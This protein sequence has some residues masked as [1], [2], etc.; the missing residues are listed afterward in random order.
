MVMFLST[1]TNVIFIAGQTASG[2]SLFALN[3][4]RK[5]NGAII[6]ADSMQV[7]DTLHILTSRPS[8]QEMKSIPHYLY[9]HVPAQEVYSTG[10][11]LSSAIKTIEEVKK[12]GFL[13]IIIG[14]TGLYFRALMGQIS[15]IPDI[16]TKIRENI[17][18]KLK[19]HGSHVLY[20]ELRDLDSIAA[21]QI[22]PSDA[23]RIARALEVKVSSGRS[24]TEFWKKHSN[25]VINLEKAQ[26]IIIMPEINELKNR[27][28]L[29]FKKML[30]SGAIDEVRNLLKMNLSFDLPIMKAIGVRDI[31]ALLN[32][33]INY[34]RTLQNGVIATNQYAKRQRTWL[35]NQFKDDWIRITS[36]DDLL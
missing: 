17:R 26:K 33:E 19:K 4:A 34:D 22:H 6:N 5:L 29:R 8:D 13:P 20:N 32:G 12:N 36:V 35:S 10:K 18:E 30:D 31:I 27:I 3:L 21:K 28:I 14:G 25:P 1:N 7:Y 9:G 24:I 2:K 15:V 23:Q 11:W 16:S